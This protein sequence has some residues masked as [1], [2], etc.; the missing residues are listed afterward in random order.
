[1]A[2]NRGTEYS[3]G[4][5]DFDSPADNPAV[6]WDFSLDGFALDVL[7]NSKAMTENSAGGKNGGKGW[8]IGYS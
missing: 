8:Y 6:Y 7:A 2:N 1:M 4:H 3:Q 5:V